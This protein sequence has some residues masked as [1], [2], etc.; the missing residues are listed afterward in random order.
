MSKLRM[1]SQGLGATY[2]LNV[3]SFTAPINA[4]ITPIQTRLMIQ[5]FPVKVNQPEVEFDVIFRSEKE[6]EQFQ[7]FVRNHQVKAL[8]NFLHPGVTL[9]WPER[10]IRNWTG[11]IKQFRAGGARR[12]YAPLAKINIS[13]ID[14]S[15]AKRTDVMSIVSAWQTIFGQGMNDGILG[16]PTL[17]E[18]LRD[19]LG[20]IGGIAI[21]SGAGFGNILGGGLGVPGL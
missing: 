15:V 18:T 19:P 4:T 10:D 3:L 6:F 16:L 17:G 9:F 21:G 1:M 13:L 12:N 7:E 20:S 2:D 8:T 5:H 14:S 11:V